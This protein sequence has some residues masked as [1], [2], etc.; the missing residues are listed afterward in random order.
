MP[1]PAILFLGLFLHLAL[2]IWFIP[3][4]LIA[5]YF[6]CLMFLT[7][8]F[9]CLLTSRMAVRAYVFAACWS[10]VPAGFV[11][12]FS[13]AHNYNVLLVLLGCFVNY[14]SLLATLRDLLCVY[15]K[16]IVPENALGTRSLDFLKGPVM[17]RVGDY[18]IF[19]WLDLDGKRFHFAGFTSPRSET[20][21]IPDE[22]VIGPG[23]LY[24]S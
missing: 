20:N 3:V 19:E 23:L 21:V 11:S 10:F 1:R 9:R 24:R 2:G 22:L 16:A 14:K 13:E 17:G 4:V 6:F 12:L 7:N 15:K 18:E 8:E 5:C